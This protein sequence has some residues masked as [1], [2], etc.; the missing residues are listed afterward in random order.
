M[1]VTFTLN[2]NRKM[3]KCIFEK[4]KFQIKLIYFC[5]ITKRNIKIYKKIYLKL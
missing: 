1:S 4:Y 5:F 3:N 2:E